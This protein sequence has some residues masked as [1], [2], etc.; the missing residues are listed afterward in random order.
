MNCENEK[1]DWMGTVELHF[2][3][4]K[5][6][7]GVVL[8]DV[9]IKDVYSAIEEAESNLTIKI[10]DISIETN[11]KIKINSFNIYNGKVDLS[12]L[13]PSKINIDHLDFEHVLNLKNAKSKNA[14]IK[15]N[16][17]NIKKLQNCNNAI[18]FSPEDEINFPYITMVEELLGGI[19]RTTHFDKTY[20]F[21]NQDLGFIFSP[22]LSQV[23]LEEFC[24]ENIDKYQKYFNEN[25]ELILNFENCAPI[26]PFWENK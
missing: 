11:V 12:I 1:F 9:P 16:I 5:L 14:E 19:G 21:E 10:P 22:R 18:F 17:E 8:L 15:I 20:Q 3:Y 4:K 6:E 25:K 23:K 2:E 26:I 13:N 24:K 7:I